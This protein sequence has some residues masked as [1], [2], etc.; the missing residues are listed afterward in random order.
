MGF[1]NDENLKKEADLYGDA[2]SEPQVVWANGVLASLAVGQ[3]LN[4]ISDWNN[5]GIDTLY[6]EYDGN[7]HTVVESQLSIALRNHRCMH[8]PLT[9]V[10]DVAL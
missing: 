8:Y 3:L 4:A 6:L 10:G 2:G 7:R 1:I 9:E 5:K